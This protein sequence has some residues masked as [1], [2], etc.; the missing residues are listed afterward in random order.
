MTC[1]PASTP[2]ILRQ[3]EP[4]LSPA[5]Y[6]KLQ[7]ERSL[8][9]KEHDPGDR[10]RYLIARMSEYIP[11]QRRPRTLCVGCRNGHELDHLAHAGFSDTVGIDLHSTDPR[12]RVMD[13]H[14]IDFADGA[15]DVVYASHCLE[16]ALDPAQAASELSRVCKVGGWI[17][18]EV[19]VRYGR[20]GADLWD[21]ESP[22]GLAALVPG[23]QIIWSECGDQIGGNRQQAARA[24]LRRLP[25]PAP[26]PQFVAPS[27]VPESELP[28]LHGQLDSSVRRY[29]VDEF[30]ER[31]VRTLPPSSRIVDIGGRRGKQRGRF[32]LH[33]HG[34]HVTCVNLSREA[35]PDLLADACAVP[36]PNAC[37]DVII[38]GEVIE[39]LSDA[40]GALQ[41]A[42]RLLAPGG[43]LLATAPYLFRLHPDPLDVARYS[44]DWW[45]R[46]L[47]LAGFRDVS[48]ESQGSFPSVLAEFIRG[49][50][51]HL[52]DQQQELPSPVNTLAPSP[53]SLASL[54]RTCASEWEHKGTDAY[55]DSFTTG[56][57]IIARL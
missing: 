24:I 57:G 28:M 27:R 38:L 52:H 26:A 30:F 35:N 9:L 36:L 3:S 41:E 43:V 5:E 40:P 45:A 49:W 23:T 10:A 46:H 6:H 34:H 4:D 14:D 19:P 54:T 7:L 50:C 32:N 31:H 53:Q 55:L 51:K 13:M 8:S 25:D 48:I 2:S 18:I 42:A 17:V 47:A 20:R 44:P 22:E 1:S 39:H 21:F 11:A 37:A 16:H 12:I 15:F 29:F 33:T 56:L